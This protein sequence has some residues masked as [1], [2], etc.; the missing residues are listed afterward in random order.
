MSR[1]L[2]P[3]E[4]SRDSAR[5]IALA[6]QGFATPRPT[7]RIDRRHLRRVIDSVGLIQID[8]VN[9][10]VRS[11]EMPLFSRLGNHPRTLI[12]EATAAGE[13]FEYWCHEASHLPV[14][15]HP[16]IRWRMDEARNGAMW[17]GLRRIAESKPKLM[18]EIR[19]RIYNDGPL[20]AGDVRTRTG[21]KGS[22]WDWDEGKAVLEYLFWTGE[23]TAQ[24]RPNDFARVY[25][26]PHDVL[27]KEILKM[28]TPSQSEARR[29]MLLL[30]A[31][32]VGVGTAA[33]LFDYHRQKPQQA[34]PYLTELVE[35]GL[36]EQVRVE[37]WRDPAYMLPDT[38]RPRSVDV[39]A[40]VSPFDSLVWC[41]PRIER[42][43]DFHYRIEIYV[44]APKR[45]YGYYV[46]PFVLGDRIVARVDLKADRHAGELLVP[47]AFSQDNVDIKHVASELMLELREMATWLGLDRVRIGTNGDLA[48]LLAKQNRQK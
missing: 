21:P 10:L 46:L 8:S 38:L 11:Q 4:I 3:T 40:L 15:M 28:P 47:G 44:P 18:K 22:W 20:V 45:V 23:I 24:R 43:F 34:K 31:R 16:L 27:P 33:D 39:R 13:L 35:E 32:S 9:V 6:A 17:P 42:L 30:A 2:S 14:S 37:G 25:Y 1:S 41:R 29:E 19:D 12:P 26:A 48:T 36:I 5:R 7:G